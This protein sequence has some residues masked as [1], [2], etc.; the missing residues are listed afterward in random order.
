M[1]Q[2]GCHICAYRKRAEGD[3]LCARCREDHDERARKCRVAIDAAAIDEF[4]AR[5]ETA[6]RTSDLGRGVSPV[7]R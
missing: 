7:E 5:P 6:H 1:A 4:A 2:G 3:F